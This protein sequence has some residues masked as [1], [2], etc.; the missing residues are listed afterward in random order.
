MVKGLTKRQLQILDLIHT[1]ID[2]NGMPPT[3]LEIANNLGFKSLNAAEDHL[4]ALEK[5]EFIKLV[6]NVSRGIKVLKKT[7]NKNVGL[8]IVGQV[9]AGQPILAI[10]HVENHILIDPFLFEKKADYLLRVKGESMLNSGIRDGD[11]LVVHATKVVRNNQIVVARLDDEVTVKRFKKAGSKIYLIPENDNFDR[12]EVNS[13][14][15]EFII[16]G[17]GIGILRLDI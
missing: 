14:Y 4:K 16:E 13:K 6:P 17:L 7:N 5:K 11:L 1:S 9:A 12:I 8:P 10:E 3:R 2:E 15:G